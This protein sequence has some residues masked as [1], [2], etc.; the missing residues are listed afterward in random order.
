[1]SMGAGPMLVFVLVYY[2]PEQDNVSSFNRLLGNENWT[3]LQHS[4]DLLIQGSLLTTKLYRLS[5]IKGNP[6]IFEKSSVASSFTD[7]ETSSSVLSVD[8][9]ELS[10][11]GSFV[12]T[13]YSEGKF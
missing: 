8:S 3:V 10:N 5:F 6:I 12:M 1:M 9:V 4:T 2:Q 13:V 11:V 7:V